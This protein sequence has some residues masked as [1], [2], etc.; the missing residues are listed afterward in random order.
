[1]KTI[2]VLLSFVAVSSAGP[3]KIAKEG[4]Q[5]ELETIT[6]GAGCF[7]CVEAI[8]DNVTGVETAISG[9]SGGKNANPSYK[10][11]C[12]GTTGHAEVCQVVYDPELISL[13]D[14]LEIFFK[15]HDPTTLNRQGADTGTQYRS[16]IFYH[17]EIQREIAEKVKSHLDSAEIWPSPIVTAIEPFQTFFKAEP[18]HQEYFQN[19]QTQPYCRLVIEPKIEKFRQVF[20]KFRKK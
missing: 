13:E 12:S 11:V 2:I 19:N 7:W 15:I 5:N 3:A 14:L 10:D 18:Y 16:V 17:N 1:M 6:L 4:G 9:Y 20:E 8:F